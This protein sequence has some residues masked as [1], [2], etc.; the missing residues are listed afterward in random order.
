[1]LLRKEK[2]AVTIELQQD[3]V[4]S[5][6]FSH[7][8][9]VLEKEKELKKLEHC[10]EILNKEQQTVI[11]Q[12]YLENKCYNEIVEATGWDWNKV[13]SAVQNARRNLKNCMEQNG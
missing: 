10:I 12:F 6:D 7:L 9:D 5:E 11:T 4:Q 2:K 8:D 1:M 3:H 13:R